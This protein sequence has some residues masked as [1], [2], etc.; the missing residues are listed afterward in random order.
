MTSW[1]RGSVSKMTQTRLL[2]LN[3]VES[4]RLDSVVLPPGSFR[5]A[6]KQIATA[7]N[8]ESL[9]GIG[10]PS[11]APNLYPNFGGASDSRPINAIWVSPELA[12]PPFLNTATFDAIS[13][14]AFGTLLGHELAH[15]I[16]PDAIGWNAAGL[17]QETW[18]KTA[19]DAFKTRVSCLERQL[20][21]MG[22]DPR[23]NAH[24]V[25]D[26]HVADVL[27]VRF[28]LAA[29]ESRATGTVNPD[30]QQHRRRDF[31]VAY[32]QQECG[33][34]GDLGVP[35][36]EQ[37]AA[38]WIRINAVLSNIPEFAATFRCSPGAVM[39]PVQRCPVW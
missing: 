28:A 29:M 3:D 18:T 25:L 33:W 11:A 35:V 12:R 26:E 22:S 13:F 23:I 19:R 4:K 15:G 6:L 36:D 24:E 1:S 2:S 39:A 20:D 7:A 38:A 34:S 30:V 10:H 32:A 8:T 9:A 21:G 16:S 17:L 14:G 5:A 27:G 31:F 37:H